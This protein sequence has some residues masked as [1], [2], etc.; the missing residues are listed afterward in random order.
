MMFVEVTRRGTIVSMFLLAW[1][2]V[3]QTGC[4]VE[5]DCFADS[6][7]GSGKECKSG[8]CVKD[9]GT[10]GGDYHVSGGDPGYP[11]DIDVIAGDFGPLLTHDGPEIR[12]L[13]PRP[14]ELIFNVMEI[15]AE[16]E[17]ADGVDTDAVFAII[18]DQ[19][20][21]QLQWDNEADAFV[22]LFD[23]DLIGR[24]VFPVLEVTARDIGGNSHTEGTVFSLDNEPPDISFTSR[25]IYGMRFGG[26]GIECTRPWQVVGDHGLRDGDIVDSTYFYQLGMFPRL[27]I[28]DDGN[29]DTTAHLAVPVFGIDDNTVAVYALDSQGS[30]NNSRKLLLGSGPG[31]KCDRINP[32]VLPDP[33]APDAPDK[34]IA[35]GLAAVGNIDYAYGAVGLPNFSPVVSQP[36][37]LPPGCERLGVLYYCIDNCCHEPRFLCA[38]SSESATY[39]PCYNGPQN[40]YTLATECHPMIY[41]V[42]AFS[43][44]SNLMCSGGAFDALNMVAD[45]IVCLTASAADRRGNLAFAAPIAICVDKDNSGNCA[46]FVGG[47]AASLCSDGCTP[48][49]DFGVESDEPEAFWFS[50]DI[51]NVCY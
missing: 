8:K 27:R 20:N 49:D 23:T 7:C 47:N 33:L 29:T 14:Y 48:A 39:Y 6:D 40:P 24:M 44:V 25:E 26:G 17:D 34:A 50:G 32:D 10:A 45:G 5:S 30:A 41:G 15:R 21:V 12:I 22:A 28:Q 18:A 43:T 42:G 31:S 2:T 16:V 51:Y 13:M 11:S 38:A 9:N 1:V 37:I 35:V 46:T 19:Y 3:A 36:A 4:V